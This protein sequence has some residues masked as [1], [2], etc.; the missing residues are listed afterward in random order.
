MADFVQ[1][2]SNLAGAGAA[3]NSFATAYQDAQDRQVKKQEAQAK[4]GAMQAQ[5]QRD[6][7]DQALKMHAAGYKQGPGG[8]TDLQPDALNPKEQN[9]ADLKV[10]GEGGM[11]GKPDDNGHRPIVADPNSPKMVAAKGLATQR[12]TTNDF[13]QDRLDLS[14]DIV[15]RREH[16]NVINKINANPNVKTRLQQYQN[17]D[18][19]LSNLAN[20]DHVTPEMFDEAQQ[21]VRSNLGIK[22]SSGVGERDLTLMKGLGLNVDRLG[23]FLSTSPADIGKDNKLMGH[24]VNLAQLEKKNITGQFSKSLEAA[25][26]G[27]KSM[28]ARRPDLMD[29]LKDAIGAQSA[30]L[31]SSPPA[32][33]PTGLVNKGLVGA[34]GLVGGAPPQQAPP[35]HAKDDQALQ[36]ATDNPKDPRS[37]AILKANGR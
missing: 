10:F 3:F 33:S 12:Q 23:E 8:P 35:P 37:A 17:L 1:D 11:Y 27:H 26:A 5:M 6:A 2:Y 15:D 36:W 18:N 19:T 32:P 13:K 31:D 20:A 21:S 14:N 28:Y 24:I 7:T 25:S 9:D 22:G 34:Q 16:Q 29:D 30:Q 4:L